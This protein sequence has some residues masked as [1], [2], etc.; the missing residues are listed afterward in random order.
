MNRKLLVLLI[1][2][3]VAVVL[4]RMAGVDFDWSLFVS[5]IWA[6]QPGIFVISML[7]T[8]A[9]YVCR[10]FRWQVLLNPLKRLRIGPLF[11][12]TMLGFT[13]IFILGRAGEFI[14][15]LWITRREQIPLTA[16][17]ATIIVERFFD[18]L[19]LIVLFGASLLLVQ[20]PASASGA[21]AL[22]KDAAWFMVASSVAAIIALFFFRSNVDRIVRYIPF[23]GIGSLLKSFSEG[24]SFLQ[25]GSSL[26]LV[27]VHSVAV[28]TTIV[29]QFWFMLIGMNF[30]FPLEVATLVMVGAAIGSVAQIPGIGGGFQAGYVFC[31]TTFFGVP[32]EQAIA[33]SLLAW[34]S[35]NIP[36]VAA[37][38]I[39]MIS[40]G[41]SLKDLRAATAAQ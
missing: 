9:T 12:A 37:S 10:A 27:I 41:L 40:Q 3:V 8:F 5:S 1:L 29:L 33:T 21:I 4:Y 23:A 17:L 20:V 26:F 25:S 36:T 24:L 34:V 13:G 16:S 35:S 14:R 31:M 7:M 11:S 30:N 22:M 28:W 39:Y 15:P 2:A 38:S 6:V 19:M 18:V 32:A